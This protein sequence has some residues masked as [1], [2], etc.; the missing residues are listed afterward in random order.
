MIDECT[1]M[2]MVMDLTVY[3]L[4]PAF[5]FDD[6]AKSLN[7]YR[8]IFVSFLKLVGSS[9]LAIFVNQYPIV[10]C[11]HFVP[12]FLQMSQ[13][14]RLFWPPILS[15]YPYSLGLAVDTW[16]FLTLLGDSHFEVRAYDGVSIALFGRS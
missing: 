7:V 16:P 6:L 14:P 1:V 5:R 8:L 3:P 10:F 15:I 2:A 9:Y 13:V 4:Y 11:L 12:S